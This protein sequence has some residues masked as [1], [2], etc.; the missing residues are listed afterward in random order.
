MN[1]VLIAGC[2]SLTSSSTALLEVAAQTLANL[3]LPADTVQIRHLPADDLL[4]GRSHSTPLRQS[5][6]LVRRADALVIATSVTKGGYTG[7]L[8]AFLD[9]LPADS[10]RNKIILPLA[11]APAANQWPAF[12]VALRAV[13]SALGARQILDGIYCLESQLQLHNCKLW[14]EPEIAQQLDTTLYKLVGMLR[15]EQETG[16]QFIDY[17][18][19]LRTRMTSWS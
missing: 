2:P 9:L 12:D 7:G 13:L 15:L 11:T 8:K 18:L 10:L 19:P 4:L 6:Q 1:I 17:R 3:G 14:I 5:S 16:T